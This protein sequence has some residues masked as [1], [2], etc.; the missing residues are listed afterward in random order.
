M[1]INQPAC[2]GHWHLC[3]NTILFRQSKCLCRFP[4]S[5]EQMLN[6]MAYKQTQ[7][8]LKWSRT[9]QKSDRLIT[10]VVCGFKNT[11]VNDGVDSSISH[12]V[13]IWNISMTKCVYGNITSNLLPRSSCVLPKTRENVASLTAYSFHHGNI[14]SL[15]LCVH[16]CVARCVGEY[17][18]QSVLDALYLH[19]KKSRCG[20][21][22]PQSLIA[23]KSSLHKTA[24]FH[25]AF[26]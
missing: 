12:S 5:R 8:S 9:M 13:T 18:F 25:S 16:V 11:V 15:C 17:L 21:R 7:S 2:H 6:H 1:V 10:P 22:T 3:Y 26:L 23:D 24:A 19:I 14:N 20:D 4:L